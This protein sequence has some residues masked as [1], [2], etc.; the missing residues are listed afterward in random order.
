[1][2][3]ENIYSKVDWSY[4]QINTSNANSLLFN[5]NSNNNNS[6]P[7]LKRQNN[8]P[9]SKNVSFGSGN[10]FNFN[11][12]KKFIKN[13][14]LDG[15][16]LSFTSFIEKG[17]F[18]RSFLVIDG[19][20][21][22]APRI[23]QGLKRNEEEN[24]GELNKRFAAKEAVREIVSGPGMFFIPY[25]ML[26][27]A[28]NYLGKITDI[29]GKASEIPA[30]FIKAFGD[31]HSSITN[32]KFT[33]KEDFFKSVFTEIIKNAKEESSVSKK[34]EEDAQKFASQ[35]I[36]GT[37]SKEKNGL[38]KVT[39]ELFEQ[40]VAISKG[41]SDVTADFTKANVKGL[42]DSFK[43]LVSNMTAYAD[44]VIENI[45]KKTP[46]N[47][48]ERIEN[49]VHK[50]TT[51][52]FILNISMYG[53]IVGL[54]QFIPILY[55]KAEGDENA[56]L[57][58][59]MNKETLHDN[60]LN[61]R[62]N[63]QL[64]DKSNPSFGSFSSVSKTITGNGTVGK[65]AS[66]MEFEGCSMSFYP[67]A[68]MMAGGILYPR[69]KNARDEYDKEEI[70][71][72]DVVTCIVMCI[73]E[74]EL[75]K[76]FSKFNEATAGLVLAY[77]DKDFNGKGMFG[78]ILDYLNPVK[79]VQ[80]LSS[81]QIRAKYTNI[82]QYN[83]G[84]KGFC[85][86]IS[87][88]GGNLSKVF[89]LDEKSKAIVTRLL[90][91]KDIATADNKIITEA[92]AKAD[93]KDIDAICELFHEGRTVKIKNPSFFDN[94]IHRR[95]KLEENKWVEKAR[96]LNA[97]FTTLSVLVLVPLFLGF[98]LPAINERATKKRIAEEQAKNASKTAALNNDSFRML[99][100]EIK[101]NPIFADMVQYSE[102][103]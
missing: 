19:T 28:K 62:Y 93:K 61:A 43:S 63:K 48:K 34:T 86:F 22:V 97:R 11:S 3:S 39:N 77:K 24:N 36:E 91:G 85:E 92:I 18:V 20:G 54:F 55:N 71:R 35:L 12:L 21:T 89:S 100:Q 10:S 49:L 81:E 47:V 82:N 1:M 69:I 56:G 44:D 8:N 17:S 67:L 58:G 80:V 70:I 9:R 29:F 74:K 6:N 96:T 14:S 103:A 16:C 102:A 90:G 60:E 37:K 79:G 50:K 4:M 83:G 13:F 25:S 45:S 98:M 7:F 51:G 2:R 64:K 84:I 26:K 59:L 65:F 75:R 88:Q 31:I 41:Q 73:G 57:K 52:R 94:L 87:N 27:L 66:T 15:I 46:S 101:K 78:K 5:K 33:S 53:A 40:F 30:K 99:M 76:I 95:V 42:S 38:S 68:G 72:R 23:F 32:G